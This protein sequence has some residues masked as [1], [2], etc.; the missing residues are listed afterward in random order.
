MR[1]RWFIKNDG[2][3]ELQ[4]LRVSVFVG[5]DGEWIPVESVIEKPLEVRDAG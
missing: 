1:L 5:E 4:W 3:K 2:T